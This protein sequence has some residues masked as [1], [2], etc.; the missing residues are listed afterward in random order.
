MGLNLEHARKYVANGWSVFPLP[1]KTKEPVVKWGQ[2][3]ERYAT[4]AELVA[5]FQDTN[6]GIGIACGRLS[7]LSVLDA[8][9]ATGM[10]LL[11]KHNLSSI[12]TVITGGGGRQLYYRFSGETNKWTSTDHEGLDARGEGGYVVAPPSLHESGMRYKWAGAV[13]NPGQ[14]AE[15][16]KGLFVPVSTVTG[17]STVLPSSEPWVVEALKGVPAGQPRHGVLIKLLTYLVP[18]HPYEVVKY[19]MNDWNSRNGEPY[20]E[21]TV[22]KQLNDI[23]GRFTKGQYK[24]RFV[25]APQEPINVPQELEISTTSADGDA[26]IADVLN[27]SNTGQAEL[28]TGFASVDEA[29][30]GVRRGGIFCV[31]AR[32][33]VGKTS[34][35]VNVTAH[36]CGLN[37]RV[38]YFSTELT[39][40]EI[41]NSVFASQAQ[42]DAFDLSNKCLNAGDRNK[43]M[44]FLPKFKGYDLHVVKL[45]KPDER[46]VSEAIAK[47][48]PDVVVI[49]HIQHISTGDKQFADID[50]FI[51]Y[52]KRTAVENNLAVIVCS[53]LHRGAAADGAVPELH[54]LKG[55]GTIEEEASVVILMH[56]PTKDA[57]RPVLFRIAKNRHGRTGDTT[58]LFDAP[59]TKFSDMQVKVS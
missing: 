42:I 55:C 6:A 50:K 22:E 59:I 33:G 36:L 32:P 29:T 49:D 10:S 25:L 2:Y 38:L 21:G 20:P 11:V 8:D 26:Y 41:Y 58:L 4:D 1:P 56:S 7:N 43:L 46:A 18:R 28:P 15:F 30:W 48:K 5:W 37:K 19:M 57:S 54:H 12:G 16:P 27:P 47:I 17:P 31:G 24:S 52:L 13:P 3:R 34:F 14:L 40:A 39:P 51:K 35:T 9:G 44:A 23:A 53:Q 45:F